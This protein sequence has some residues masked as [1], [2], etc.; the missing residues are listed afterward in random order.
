MFNV[1]VDIENKIAVIQSVQ[2]THT[3][4]KTLDKIIKKDQMSL[5]HKEH[6]FVMLFLFFHVVI[7]PYTTKVL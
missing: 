3:H 4:K 6:L 7:L 2:T 1:I 5:N